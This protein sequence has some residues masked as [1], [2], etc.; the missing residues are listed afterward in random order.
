MTSGARARAEAEALRAVN[1]PPEPWQDE[2]ELWSNEEEE[3]QQQQ[4][5]MGVWST[6]ATDVPSAPNGSLD[7]SLQ[8]RASLEWSTAATSDVPRAGHRGSTDAG[9]P[10]PSNDPSNGA[11][12]PLTHTH[13]YTHVL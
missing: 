13:A 8:R 11:I 6:D 7:A 3:E 9:M 5:P 1:R 12:H 4:Q 2:Q 10:V